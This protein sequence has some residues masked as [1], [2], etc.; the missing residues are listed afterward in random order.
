MRFQIGPGPRDW[1]VRQR[2]DAAAGGARST[3][4]AVTGRRD[5]VAIKEAAEAG[6]LALPNVHLVGVG[7]KIT[8]GVDTGQVAIV[9][10]V[11]AKKGPEQLGDGESVPREI[12]GVF[13]DVVEVG[14]FVPLSDVPD[15][16]LVGDLEA[17]SVRVG[18]ARIG[19]TEVQHPTGEVV[20]QP[21]AG[22]MGCVLRTNGP[23]P[24]DVILTNK[25][26]VAVIESEPDAS[27]RGREIGQPHTQP[28]SACAP[29]CNHIIGRV[30]KTVYSPDVDGALVALAPGTKW[31]ADVIGLGP[32]A[33]V[34]DVSPDTLTDAQF[35]ALKGLS[36]HK[37]GMKTGLTDG[38]LYL[39]NVSGPFPSPPRKPNRMLHNQIMVKPSA[40][41]GVTQRFSVRGDSGSVVLDDQRRVLGLLFSGSD[42]EKPSDNGYGFAI[43][44]PIGRVMSELGVQVVSATV[45]NQVVR[46]PAY[47]Y[48]DVPVAHEMHAADGAAV[49]VEAADAVRH[50]HAE[51]L[52]TPM[53]QL[54]AGLV[55]K[56]GPEVRD[57]LENNRRV[58]VTWHRNGGPALVHQVLCAIQF[59]QARVPHQLNGRPFQEAVHRIFDVLRRFGSERLVRDLDRHEWRAAQLSGMS[60]LDVLDY[61]RTSSAAVAT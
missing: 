1:V 49:R 35:A 5:L 7:P 60:Y 30:V 57:L 28:C 33:D 52:E 58:A 32:I 12:D 50:A 59:H 24:L 37:R 15:P 27:V 10:C 29:C 43:F 47:N 46:A 26:V 22:T 38:V 18:G 45:A 2:S 14:R 6:L 17:Y 11:S 9:A 19:W 34:R 55:E 61:V 8:A 42:A 54:Y 40:P 56:H 3:V 23:N 36:V 31:S 13:T 53:G 4:A 39:N 20:T 16:E 41:G 48:R 25:H 44:C 21:H 51:L